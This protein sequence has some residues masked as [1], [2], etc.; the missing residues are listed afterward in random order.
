[1]FPPSPRQKASQP[2]HRCP[3]LQLLS[4]LVQISDC[5]YVPL[6]L[7]P[8]SSCTICQKS[9][10]FYTIYRVTGLLRLPN[11]PLFQSIWLTYQFQNIPLLSYHQRFGFSA[12]LFMCCLLLLHLINTLEVNSDSVSS[13]K[14]AQEQ[15]ISPVKFSDLIYFV[16]CIEATLG[17]CNSSGFYLLSYTVL[18]GKFV[19]RSKSILFFILFIYFGW[20]RVLVAAF[21]PDL[22][23]HPGIKLRALALGVE[24]YP[25][26][27]QGSPSKSILNT[28]WLTKGREDIFLSSFLHIQFQK[29]HFTN[30]CYYSEKGW[31][32]GTQCMDTILDKRHLPSRPWKPSHH[33][34]V[35]LRPKQALSLA[36]RKPRVQFTTTEAISI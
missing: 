5:S 27:H 29:G 19:L 3:C 25:L 36:R 2:S 10:E 4:H 7:T 18:L 35:F 21:M 8:C 30:K 1:M 31:N 20:A 9:P 26:D 11:W 22:V 12:L 33:T 16:L 24:S 17:L 28:C 6:H 32:K 13:I 34:Q 15:G 14:T 23:P